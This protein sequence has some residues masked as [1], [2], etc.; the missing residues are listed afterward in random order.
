MPV[1]K[2]IEPLRPTDLMKNEW[3]GIVDGEC[4][5]TDVKCFGVNYRGT[6]VIETDAEGE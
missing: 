4:E 3:V 5:G 2:L 6:Y 1:T